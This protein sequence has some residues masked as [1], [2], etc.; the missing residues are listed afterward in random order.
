MFKTRILSKWQLK[1][2]MI[3]FYENIG[4]GYLSNKR[5]VNIH[6]NNTYP[7]IVVINPIPIDHN[8]ITVEYLK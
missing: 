5:I 3:N 7:V 6:N 8:L 1:I 4:Y 2:S